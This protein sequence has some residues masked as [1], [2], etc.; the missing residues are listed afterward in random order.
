MHLRIE[1]I[2]EN[3]VS[4]Q[5][6]K[7]DYSVADIIHKELLNVKHVKFSGVPPPHPLIKTLTIRI[8]TDG[9]NPT[10]SL[11]GAVESSQQKVADLLK[12]SKQMFPTHPVKPATVSDSKPTPSETETSAQRT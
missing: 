8:H 1:S 4:V 12:I 9:A 10:K 2:S 7:E 6:D 11:L 3:A 5:I